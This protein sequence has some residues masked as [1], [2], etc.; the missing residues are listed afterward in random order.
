MDSG[1]IQLVDTKI[2]RLQY[3]GKGMRIDGGMELV[4]GLHRLQ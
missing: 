4:R 2:G 3:V 1:K